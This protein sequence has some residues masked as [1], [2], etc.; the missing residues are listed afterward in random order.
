MKPDFNLSAND[1]SL[2]VDPELFYAKQRIVGK[3]YDLFGWLSAQYGELGAGLP[4]ETAVSPKI[5]RGENYRYLPY[6]ML[7]QP[8]LFQQEQV[9]AIRSLFWWGQH[10]SIHLLLGGRWKQRYQEKILAHVQEDGWRQWYIAF[11]DDPWE[12]HFEPTNY[13]PVNG[14]A[15]ETHTEYLKLGAVLPLQQWADAAAFF[16]DAYKSLMLLFRE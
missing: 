16:T 7:D 15:G 5:Y 9:F 10:F 11:T 6:V 4:P 12:H 8:R 1:F 3:V 13:M 2:V 14:F